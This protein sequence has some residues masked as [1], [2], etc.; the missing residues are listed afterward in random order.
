[1]DSSH[2]EGNSALM[3]HVS[4]EMIL[5]QISLKKQQVPALTPEATAIG[6]WFGEL[7]HHRFCEK[8]EAERRERQKSFKLQEMRVH[9]R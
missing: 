4:E 7:Q 8:S 1:M 2:L 9:F 5:R 3:Y 6:C